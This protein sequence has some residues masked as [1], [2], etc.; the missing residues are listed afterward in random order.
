MVLLKTTPGKIFWHEN[1]NKFLKIETFE[2]FLNVVQGL[3]K[4]CGDSKY[5][6]FFVPKSWRE[7]KYDDKK[8]E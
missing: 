2:P 4:V 1:S 7:V 6:D 5:R 3:S 8:E